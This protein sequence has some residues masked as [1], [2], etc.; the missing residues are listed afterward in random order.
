MLDYT[1]SLADAWRDWQGGRDLG[2][3]PLRAAA[4]VLTGRRH[5]FDAPF[6]TEQEQKTRSNPLA[7]E[8]AAV[9]LDA[10][11]G[12][13]HRTAFEW[14]QELG[15][16]VSLFAGRGLEPKPDYDG[17]IEDALTTGRVEMPLWGVSL[18]Y[19]V[20][21]KYGTGKSH[22]FPR[23]IFAI[24][25]AFPAVAAWVHSGH[26]PEEQELICGGEYTVVDT[27]VGEMGV[28]TVRFEY[29]RPIEQLMPKSAD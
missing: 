8:A 28:T 3:T 5:Y 27:V 25:G 9:L 6:I 20:A 21:W 26:L 19:D 16:P 18:D 2:S 23:F 14:S 10:V 4:R 17:Q 22:R 12:A 13:P 24:A 15:L 7:L 1:E 29:L 11:N